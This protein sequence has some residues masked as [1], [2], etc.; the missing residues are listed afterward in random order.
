MHRLLARARLLV[1]ALLLAPLTVSAQGRLTSPEQFFGHRIG[2][3]YQLPNYT[4]FLA[5]F[6]TLA[7]ESERMQL[8]T[9]GFT[10][11]GRPQVMGII[12]SPANLANKERYQQ[13]SARLSR[14]EGLTDDEARRLAKEGKAVV[15]IDGG[16]HATEVLGAQQLMETTWQLVSR[17]D[18]ETRRFLDDVIILVAHA[19]PDGMEL[20][21]D[22]YMREPD[23]LRR[24]TSGVPRLYQKYAGHDN[25]R[26]SYMNALAE[27][28]NVSRVMYTQWYPQI[29]YNHHQTG[30][31]GTVMFAP[32]FR[33][34][35][36]YN[37]HPLIITGI[38]LV[39]ASMHGRFVAEK[40]GGTVM[41]SGAS[42]ST[43]WNGGLRTTAYFHNQ[44]GLLTETIGNPTPMTIPLV[45]ARQLR[46]G[47]QPLPVEPGRWH[48]RQSVDYSVTANWAV[49]DIASR[50]RE[51]FLYNIYAMGR[52]AIE[53]GNRD[54]WTIWPQR[55]ARVQ[56][57]AG[58]GRGGAGAGGGGGGG[59]GGAGGGADQ[60]R[61]Q[62]EST[63]RR[64]EDR[65]PRA[66]ILSADQGDYGS[67]VRLMRTLQYTGVDIHRATAPFTAGGKQYPAGS[68]VVQAAQAFRPMILDLFEPQ[69]HPNDFRFPGAPPTPPY[70]NAGW[71]LAMQFG[72]QYDRML[73]GV[74]GPLEKVNGLV[75]ATPAVLASGGSGWLLD[76]AQNDAA[77]T[78]NRLLKANAAVFRTTQ[79]TTVGGTTYP[80]GTWY[81]PRNGVSTR[82]LTEAARSHG[83]RTVASA[84]PAGA[85]RIKALRVGVVDRYGGLMPAGWT[86]LILK[87]FEFP[88]TTVFPQE[89]DA[90]NLIRTYDVLIFVSGA[91][92]ANLGEAGEGEIGG[93]Q[94]QSIPEEFRAWQGAITSNKTI[95]AIKAFVE[96]G[97]TA[98]A[99]G[100]STALGRHLG[101]PIENYLVENGQPLPREKYYIPGSLLEVAVDQSHPLTAGLGSRATVM[102]DNS[103]VLKIGAGASG[104]RTVARFDTPT[105][106]RSGWAWGQESLQNGVAVAEASLG[107]G[108]VILSG[109]E[110][111]FR[112][113]PHGTFKFVFNALYGPR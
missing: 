68:F 24:S 111:L 91:V 101:L 74:T 48:F 56:A 26:D 88:H 80:A 71:T 32:P 70:D 28:R 37:L 85:Q 99:I 18:E 84:Q 105:P 13:I 30:P 100:G 45:A 97:G 90:G 92:G 33:D 63:L 93:P 113:Q 35:M 94:A 89:L 6:Q 15:W 76:P 112:A 86:R 11:E 72:V 12:S 34:P 77:L 29:M 69:D 78:A 20:V 27:T 50:H 67:V 1:L 66:Y 9:I 102:F 95:P 108:T 58:G 41:R 47:D 49:L 25:N 54:S 31:A 21:S 40:K 59:R 82:V 43:W 38:D 96:A 46:S 5:Y 51:Q 73:D 2:A 36:N 3:D 79:A 23:S 64:P 53:A 17:T 22:W 106:L 8:D 104:I 62:F 42:Y 110:I 16:L 7:R 87:S 44:L 60:V 52:D 65:D 75:E 98:I 4:K 39:G 10:E 61:Q 107:R 109:P 55:V 57:P 103:P 83:V 14:A 19:N 81:V